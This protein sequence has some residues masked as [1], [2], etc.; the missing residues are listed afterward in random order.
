MLREGP[1]HTAVARTNMSYALWKL[2]RRPSSRSGGL[3]RKRLP[4]AAFLWTQAWTSSER[5]HSGMMWKT[6][7]PAPPVE[8]ARS[9]GELASKLALKTDALL[10]YA[11]KPRALPLEPIGEAGTPQPPRSR[12]KE[13]RNHGVSVRDTRNSSTL[14]RSSVVSLYRFAARRPDK[15]EPHVFPV[16]KRIR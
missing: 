4:S 15:K 9:G 8:R 11:K 5:N 6:A 16:I 10:K 12:D 13:V 2:G 3:Q 1:R 7:T 14:L